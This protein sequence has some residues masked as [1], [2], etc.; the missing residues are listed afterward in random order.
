[1]VH[2]AAAEQY[3]R[4]SRRGP[5][6]I[7]DRHYLRELAQ[8]FVFTLV[9]ITGVSLFASAGVV[10]YKD[11]SVSLPLFLQLVRCTLVQSLAFLL[12]L[13]LLIAVVFVYGRAA[14]DHEITTLKASGIHPFRLLW[15][16]VVVA[17]LLSL[18]TFEV[19][20]RF[21]PRAAWQL[22]ALPQ[23]EGTLKTLLEKRLE[24][25]ERSLD[26]GDRKARRKLLWDRIEALDG[27]GVLLERVMLETANAA[28]PETGAPAETTHVRAPRATIR[29]D[30]DQDRVVLRLEKPRVLSGAL[31]DANQEVM[32]VVLDLSELTD[33]DRLKLQDLSELVALD[34][35]GSE[36]SPLSGAS[37]LRR[38]DRAEVSGRIHQ[39]LA[40]SATPLVFLLLG[41]PLAM[42]FRSGNRMIAFLLATLIGLFVYYPAERLADVLMSQQLVAP[43]LACW[44]GN[45]L[46]SAIG[47]GL[48]LFVVKR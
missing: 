39:R 46:L 33:R 24:A 4:E 21:A 40:R 18:L 47:A 37:L 34:A 26:F 27:G 31:R 12:P 1:L 44:S 17:L 9:V 29:F 5:L 23:Q 14:A 41:V 48:L 43:A 25:G 22:K 15:P 7:V 20:H 28:D 32:H 8:N 38:F 35:R 16:G 3:G 10:F 6:T 42:V 36:R 13:S 19:E 45:L 11:Q 2:G 30:A